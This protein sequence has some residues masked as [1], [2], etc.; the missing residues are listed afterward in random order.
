MD[1]KLTLEDFVR[2]A[3]P[4]TDEEF[5]GHPM[6]S[7][8][9]S[10]MTEAA[11]AHD[12][13][14]RAI[15]YGDNRSAYWNA[16]DAIGNYAAAHAAV[17][18]QDKASATAHAT[19]AYLDATTKA[20]SEQPHLYRL[21][22]RS[23]R[24]VDTVTTSIFSKK[25][26]YKPKPVFRW[27]ERKL[28]CGKVLLA[29]YHDQTHYYSARFEFADLIHDFCLDFDKYVREEMSRKKSIEQSVEELFLKGFELIEIDF[30]LNDGSWNYMFDWDD[31]SFIDS[32]DKRSFL[33]GHAGDVFLGH[34]YIGT[35]HANSNDEFTFAPFYFRKEIMMQSK[36]RLLLDGRLI[37]PGGVE[38]RDVVESILQDAL[39]HLHIELVAKTPLFHMDDF[40]QMS[41][42]RLRQYLRELCDNVN[43]K[44]IFTEKF[45]LAVAAKAERESFTE[46]QAL[47]DYFPDE[48]MYDNALTLV[49]KK[50]LDTEQLLEITRRIPANCFDPFTTEAVFRTGN[51]ELIQYMLRHKNANLSRSKELIT[52]QGYESQ[53]KIKSEREL[54]FEGIQHLTAE[55]A[56]QYLELSNHD[57]VLTLGGRYFS[58]T[59]DQAEQVAAFGCAMA[60]IEQS[61]DGMLLT[62][63]VND[64]GPEA[65]VDE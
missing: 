10:Y 39:S 57:K 13:A 53:R 45:T 1:E 54:I 15:K 51:R 25:P 18:M 46:A 42:D 38:P 4:I 29:E 50:G 16:L 35:L 30:D 28:Y 23:N 40:R 31:D 36:G 65:K 63:P 22:S 26:L 14:R 37:V 27:E 24:N 9:D 8:W 62:I 11:T 5:E 2:H 48:T 41:L 44:S 59:A 64:N 52:G 17:E 34:C 20:R 21:Y 55:E 58:M 49:V 7:L 33:I 43:D 19:Q 60:Y 3:N 32:G 6:F 56:M 47:L 12:L 61:E